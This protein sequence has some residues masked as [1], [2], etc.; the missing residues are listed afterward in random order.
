M[1]KVFPR[2]QNPVQSLR[3][4]LKVGEHK[5]RHMAAH[6]PRRPNIHNTRARSYRVHCAPPHWGHHVSTIVSE[7]WSLL[8]KGLPPPASSAGCCLDRGPV[9][10]TTMR[11]S[12]TMT[13][14]ASAR[15]MRSCSYSVRKTFHTNPWPARFV[16][17]LLPGAGAV[18]GDAAAGLLSSENTR[19][20]SAW[21]EKCTKTG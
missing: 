20:W 15:T 19:R 4:L 8:C 17:T 16:A 10:H 18:V 14:M 6:T 5:E 12:I 13:E 2:T 11:S 9:T 7:S 1:P 21:T 3:A